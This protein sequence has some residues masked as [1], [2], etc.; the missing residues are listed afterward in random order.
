DCRQAFPQQLAEAGVKPTGER[1]RLIED[2]ARGWRDWSLVG[3]DNKEHW[4]YQTF[5]VND[6]AF[7]GPRGASLALEI[8]TTAPDNTLAVVLETD[9]WRSYTGRKT[10][11]YVAMVPLSGTGHHS[12]TLP[13]EKFVTAEGETLE[14]YDLVTS[15]TLTPGQK[16]APE[17][18]PLVW[19]GAIPTFQNIRWEGGEFA[20]RPRPYLKQG[21]SEIDADAAFRQ[22]F[23]NAVDE[24]VK[25][26]GQDRQ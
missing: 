1:Q 23:D 6:P 24:S 12:I 4:N 2:F 20:P 15:L 8:E 18:V 9:G 10:R 22:Q 17:K 13:I 11:R 16:E 5:K 14:N 25:R 7:F 3:A 26:E 21:A 19:Q